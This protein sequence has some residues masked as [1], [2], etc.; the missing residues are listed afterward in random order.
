MSSRASWLADRAHWKLVAMA[1]LLAPVCGLVVARGGR[2]A[3]IVLA[4]AALAALAIPFSHLGHKALWVWLLAMPL[5]YP[6]LRYPHGKTVVSFDRV[7][8]GAMVLVV[9]V[10]ATRATPRQGAGRMMQ[11]TLGVLLVTFGIRAA[12]TPS[13]TITQIELWIDALCVPFGLFLVTRS[14]VS[15]TARLR[16]LMGFVTAAGVI[17]ALIGLAE[18]VFGFE[19]A[20]FSGGQRRYDAAIG[21]TR[22][23]GPFS[24]PEPYALAL[25]GTLAA[26]L[27]W[28][29]MRRVPGWFG[30]S[31]ILIQAAAIALSYFRAAWIGLAIVLIAG[32]VAG[33]H[34]R[35]RRA[36][37]IGFGVA[38]AYVGVAVLQHDLAVVHTRVSNVANVYGRL[39]A[40][41]QGLNLFAGHP[42]FGVGVGQ[43]MKAAEA[44][45]PVVIHG[46]A[47]VDDPHSSYVS[48]LAEQGVVGFL[49]LLAVGVAAWW[50]IRALRRR[51]AGPVD[52]VLARNVGGAALGYLVMSLTLTMITYE[53]S[54]AI[55]AVLFGAVAARLDAS[56]AADR[57]LY[58]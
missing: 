45:P 13:S 51:A 25:L 6:F 21:L 38:L 36:A 20:T 7:W 30:T 26:T 41:R 55:F 47:A 53:P 43:Y 44:A 24:A 17:I 58:G 8:V 40:Y 23:A 16:Q 11:V 34:S 31:L 33:T 29:R 37:L 4:A 46:Y 32:T 49:P 39:A 27:T 12:L 15:S 35:V 1:S 22:V 42:L 2:P 56:R 9:L 14:V 19:L 54:N 57:S 3:A 18:L 10:T 5:A 50:L 28:L 48:T 52:L